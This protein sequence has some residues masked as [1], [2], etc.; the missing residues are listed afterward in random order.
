MSLNTS[1]LRFLFWYP[2]VDF[3]G[4]LSTPR[5]FTVAPAAVHQS[6]LRP[7]VLVGPSTYGFPPIPIRLG[8]G[9]YALLNLLSMTAL[10]S[11]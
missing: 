7:T 1:L 6:S 4:A 9:T 2:S 8:G 10:L 3:D 11:L 5:W